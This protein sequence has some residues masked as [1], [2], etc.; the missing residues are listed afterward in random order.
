[1]KT[2]FRFLC[3]LFAAILFSPVALPAAD[4]KPAPPKPAPKKPSRQD[5]ERRIK[6]QYPFK[7]AKPGDKVVFRIT[8]GRIVR[9]VVERILPNGVRIKD[10]EFNIVV[11]QKRETIE[12]A[13][14]AT[15]FYKEEYNTF[16]KDEVDHEMN[17]VK[18]DASGNKQ[19]VA[20]P[21]D[22]RFIAPK[23]K[24]KTNFNKKN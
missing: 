22:K 20:K 10:P 18:F 5:I 2:P 15:M 21:G 11:L 7:Q 6:A 24:A 3:L 1:M 23:K 4:P 19:S 16:I 13:F 14:R 17:P 8:N 12:L 9:G